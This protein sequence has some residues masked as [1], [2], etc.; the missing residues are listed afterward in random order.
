[1]KLYFAAFT[2]WSAPV[3]AHFTAQ[4]APGGTTTSVTALI[5]QLGL[6][7]VFLWMWSQERKERIAAQTAKDAL[8]E[9]VLPLLVQ[10]TAALSDV[11]AGMKATIE[12]GTPDRRDFDLLFRRVELLGDEL[13]DVI[14]RLK[15]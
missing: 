4:E 8:L 11:Q 3:V 1:M 15:R 9:R 13:G 12:R 2:A 10:C 5:V 14:G 7:G 6:S